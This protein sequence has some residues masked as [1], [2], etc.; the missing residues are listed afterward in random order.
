[1]NKPRAASNITDAASLR[2]AR[3]VAYDDFRKTQVVGRLTKQLT[4]MS[5]QVLAHLWSSCGLNNEASL[6]AVGGY[7]R[8]A[9]F[10]HSDIDILIL[11][12]TEEKKALALSKQV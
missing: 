5:D 1:M 8:N 2:A 10:P 9:L 7:G 12:P 6:I 4:K 3:E 11:L